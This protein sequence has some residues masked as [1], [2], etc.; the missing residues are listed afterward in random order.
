MRA[1]I[2]VFVSFLLIV[3]VAVVGIVGVNATV[4][5]LNAR[6]SYQGYVEAIEL[7]DMDVNVIATCVQDAYDKGYT[8]LIDT[9]DLGGNGALAELK[10]VYPF[11]ISFIGL[12]TEHEIKSY[13]KN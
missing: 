9:F 1:G 2:E 7:S 6:N 11:K 3:T 10:M 5:V 13:I 4:D 12:D 8:L